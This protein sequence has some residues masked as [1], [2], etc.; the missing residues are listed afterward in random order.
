MSTV[1]SVRTEQKVIEL[2]DAM[3]I[4]LSDA[5]IRGIL[6]AAEFKLEH[7]PEKYSSETHDLFLALQKKNLD[8][9]TEWLGIQKLREKRISEFTE[10]KRKAEIPASQKIL[11]FSRDIE[12]NI[13]ITEDQ[14][15]PKW[16]TRKQAVLP[17]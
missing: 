16:H 1:T 8:E 13:W 6:L 9:F 2:A 10:E 5:L 15:D 4:L 7:E 14:F 17:V 11:V 12:E 3:D